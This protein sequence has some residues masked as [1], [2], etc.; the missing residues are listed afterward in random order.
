MPVFL[1]RE[2]K[3]AWPRHAGTVSGDSKWTMRW[4]LLHVN[5][6][7]YVVFDGDVPDVPENR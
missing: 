4:V 1:F 6:T 5:Y 2:D 7:D 3:A